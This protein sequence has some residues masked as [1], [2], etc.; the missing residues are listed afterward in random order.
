MELCSVF[1]NTIINGYIS[2]R[3]C[4]PPTSRN[5]SLMT[6]RLLVWQLLLLVAGVTNVGLLYSLF[7]IWPG[8]R[9]TAP[10]TSGLKDYTL[11]QTSETLRHKLTPTGG[12]DECTHLDDNTTGY[13]RRVESSVIFYTPNPKPLVIA[14][15]I[16]LGRYYAQ[17]DLQGWTLAYNNFSFE[18]I[19]QS[20]RVSIKLSDLSVF[21]CLGIATQDKHCIR[22]ASYRLLN[23]GQ[24]INQIHGLRDSLWRK[25]GMCYTLREA[26]ASYQGPHNF[27]FP[28]WVLPKDLESLKVSIT[29]CSFRY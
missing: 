15:D 25:D 28:C 23:Q 14:K 9:C 10:D 3:G 17:R 6:L 12:C 5:I 21:L 16:S 24:R 29:V 1:Q 19:E 4:V 20:Y 8:Y 7:S 11:I 27:T 22:P 18:V 26:L 13:I 2:L